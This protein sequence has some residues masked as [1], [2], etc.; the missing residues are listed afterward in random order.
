MDEA[1]FPY[2]DK[3]EEELRNR[4]ETL[5]ETFKN[6]GIK[7]VLLAC[8]T[9]SSIYY[10]MANIGGI[11]VNNVIKPVVEYVNTKKFKNIAVLATTFTVNSRIY[12]E[13]LSGN[14]LEIAT[15]E[16]IR[17][18]E[19]HAFIESDAV[20]LLNMIDDSVDV[21]VLGCTH[22]I[23]VKELFVK[24]ANIEIITQDKFKYIRGGKVSILRTI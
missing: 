6:R 9:L 21:V 2:G 16:Y 4:V 17:K 11:S 3:T 7:N 13:K 14:V 10:D 20:D 18:I 15:D 22:Y 23:A 24:N 5:I 8:N 12:S 19:E 1:Y